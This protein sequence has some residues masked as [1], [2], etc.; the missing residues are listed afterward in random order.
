MT[1]QARI[2]GPAKLIPG[3][4]GALWK[5][6]PPAFLRRFRQRFQHGTG[7][8]MA[9]VPVEGLGQQMGGVAARGAGPCMVAAQH[10]AVAGMNAALDDEGGEPPPACSRAARKP[11][12]GARWRSPMVLLN[13]DF[14]LTRQY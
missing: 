3:P 12:G 2:R 13:D 9:L 11:S 10:V 4:A 6:A 7:R 1:E 5:K 14:A 8:R